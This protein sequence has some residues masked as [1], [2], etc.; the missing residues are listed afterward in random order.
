MADRLNVFRE[1]KQ[2]TVVFPIVPSYPVGSM[3][4]PVYLIYIY[5]PRLT[6]NQI[7][8]NVTKIIKNICH[9]W[10]LWVWKDSV[11]VPTLKDSHLGEPATKVQKVLAFFLMNELTWEMKVSSCD[12]FNTPRI[13][14]FNLFTTKKLDSVKR[15]SLPSWDVNKNKRQPIDPG[16]NSSSLSFLWHFPKDQKS[17]SVSS[18]CFSNKQ[19]GS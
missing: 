12:Y 8:P 2:K 14:V 11:F 1:H 18:Q 3:Y 9:T 6:I 19:I 10:I 13:K 4:G 15:R 7:Q 5:I 17:I 16:N